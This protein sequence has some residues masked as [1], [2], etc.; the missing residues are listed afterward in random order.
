[1]HSA[2]QGESLVEERDMRTAHPELVVAEGF[3][4]MPSVLVVVTHQMY[5]SSFHAEERSVCTFQQE[6]PV[7]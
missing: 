1:M 2:G 3:V 7:S 5:F 4:V 6:C